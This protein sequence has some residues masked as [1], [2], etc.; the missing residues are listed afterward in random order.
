MHDVNIS[1]LSCQQQV[2]SQAE[3]TAIHAVARAHGTLC[4]RVK[5]NKKYYCS[6]PVEATNVKSVF[7]A[8]ISRVPFDDDSAN[9][10]GKATAEHTNMVN[11]AKDTERD[12]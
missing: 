11:T 1:V 7:L 9:M 5:Q 3:T 4:R 10:N 8:T 6:T 12:S 2:H